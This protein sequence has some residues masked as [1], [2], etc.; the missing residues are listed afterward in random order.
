MERATC[1][2]CDE[3][4]AA[5]AVTPCSPA[6]EDGTTAGTHG[7]AGHAKD[8]PC[9]NSDLDGQIPGRTEKEDHEKAGGRHEAR[10]RDLRIAKPAI[11]VPTPPC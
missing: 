10:T 9:A 8:L 11:N 1:V 2:T 5:L 4:I 7:N 3:N 6:P